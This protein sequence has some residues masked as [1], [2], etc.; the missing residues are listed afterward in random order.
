MDLRYVERVYNRHHLGSNRRPSF[1][2]CVK[3]GGSCT[4]PLERGEPLI[5]ILMRIYTTSTSRWLKSYR[6]RPEC[7]FNMLPAFKEERERRE[8]DD[9][10][11]LFQWPSTHPFIDMREMRRLEREDL[12]LLSRSPGRPRIYTPEAQKNRN[13]ILNHIRVIKSRTL[14]N[15]PTLSEDKL[16]QRRERMDSMIQSLESQLDSIQQVGL[17]SENV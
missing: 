11:A 9:E 16:R 1:C 7:Y 14:I 4:L 17:I 15:P 2:A 13:K 10:M 6:W 8:R 5:M 12:K 3:Y